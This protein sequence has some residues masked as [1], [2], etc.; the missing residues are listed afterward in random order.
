MKY[1]FSQHSKRFEKLAHVSKLRLLYEVLRGRPEGMKCRKDTNTCDQTHFHP[2]PSIVQAARILEL[3][4]L[5]FPLSNAPRL[6]SR[7]T[8]GFSV[9]AAGRMGL[10][11]GLMRSLFHIHEWLRRHRVRSPVKRLAGHAN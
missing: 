7:A 4:M 9:S 11:G 5:Y 1:D 3:S 6:V 8:A 2:F 10:R